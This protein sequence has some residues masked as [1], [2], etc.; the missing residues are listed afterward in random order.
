M[1]ISIV[2]SSKI[3]NNKQNIIIIF[4][5]FSGETK[6]VK[7]DNFTFIYANDT[8]V[9]INVFDYKK[10]LETVEDGYHKFSNSNFLKISKMFPKEM[11][12]VKN[13][14]FLRIGLITEIKDHPKNNKLKTLT[15]ELK[16]KREII[17][18][19]NLNNLEVGEKRLFAI[20]GAFLA[21]GIII[22]ESK[23]MGIDSQGMICSYKSIGINQEGI[24]LIEN[25]KL[26]EEY[27]F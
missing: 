27:I 19:T 2:T 1:S 23:I 21:T 3:F 25:E 10:E 14:S 8:L 15:I 5:V 6:I 20:N 18:I 16:E 22:K 17:V 24:V 11:S 7:N 13:D 12:G 9:G 4:G 26:S